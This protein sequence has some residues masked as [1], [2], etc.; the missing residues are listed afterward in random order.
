MGQDTD[1]KRRVL[2][3]AGGTGGHIYPAISVEKALKELSPGIETQFICGSRPLEIELYRMA[4]AFPIII[5]V[6]SMGSGFFSKLKSLFKLGIGFFRTLVFLIK[7]K[8]DLIMGQGG[9]ITA[10]VLLAARILGIPYLLQEQNSVPGRTNL[11]FAQGAGKVYCSFRG[12]VNRFQKSSGNIKSVY[13]G[14]P[15]R[16]EITNNKKGEKKTVLDKFG[17]D[18]S[19]PVL[20]I[21]GGSQGALRL[22]QLILETLYLLEERKV[23]P[24][25]CLWSTGVRNLNWIKEDLSKKNLTKIK[26]KLLS[27]IEDMGAA[28]QVADL[29]VSRAGACSVAELM[30][31]GVPSVFCPLPHAIGNH[32]EYNAG[33]AEKSGAAFVIKEKECSPGELADIIEELLSS[34]EKRQFMS[35]KAASLFTHNSAVNIASDI[36]KN[37]N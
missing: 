31:C 8:P 37:M 30:A 6:K 16:N 32:Q 2:F 17:M 36:K 1:R 13:S 23:Q 12:A 11:F 15:L 24:F 3:A 19:L 22:Y 25:Q 21:T 35:K 28:Y 14:M 7:W 34:E 29:A 5:D 4:G 9:Y 10:P 27:Y 18:S 33:E 26:V 20:L